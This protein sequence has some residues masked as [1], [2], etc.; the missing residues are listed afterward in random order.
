MTTTSRA[1]ASTEAARILAFLGGQGLAPEQVAASVA[2]LRPAM[3]AG[4]GA[5]MLAALDR[6]RAGG[7]A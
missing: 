6:A 5:A 7:A 3:E 4:N 1:S 2:E